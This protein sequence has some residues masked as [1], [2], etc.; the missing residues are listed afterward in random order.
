[1]IEKMSAQPI[2]QPIAE[3]IRYGDS[4]AV[5]RLLADGLDVNERIRGIENNP[6]A[7]VFA[8]IWKRLE[9]V[10]ILLQAGACIDAAD[11]GG[12]TACHVAL[13]HCL[14]FRNDVFRLLLSFKPN[15]DL[16]NK[17]GESV[18]QIVVNYSKYWDI[19]LLF[20][21]AGAPL[22]IASNRL[23]HFAIKS[24][25]H[26]QV[27]LDRGVVVRDL[28]NGYGSSVL[29]IAALNCRD[30][31]VLCALINIF[32]DNLEVRDKSGYTA[33][34][35]AL[36]HNNYVAL[37]ALINAGADV[38]CGGPPPLFFVEDYKCTVAL[39]AAGSLFHWQ[40]PMQGFT[41]VHHACYGGVSALAI[42]HAFVAAGADLDVLDNDGE[43]ARQ[44][45]AKRNLSVDACQIE[46]ARQ[47]IVKARLG[48]IRYRALQVCLGLQSLALPALQVCE[49][50]LFAC[51]PVAPLVPFHHWWKIATTIKHFER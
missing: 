11:D 27:L 5:Q 45:L 29:H 22:E 16:K 17:L 12:T 33:I 18:F 3:A 28:T 34:H 15:L 39:L 14:S 42:V 43:T 49:I 32:A 13:S 2:A 51:G 23:C 35:N 30:I 48:F 50:L 31:S 41:P 36:K 44:L 7:L 26:I 21:E 46:M 24:T 1:V 20:I 4:V 19:L 8:M 37:C 10:K 40:E 6:P 25:R 38:N 9:I 47:D